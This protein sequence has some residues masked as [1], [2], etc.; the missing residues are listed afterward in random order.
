MG[1][2]SGLAV[3]LA[4]S[5]AVVSGWT[6]GLASSDDSPGPVGSPASTSTAGPDAAWG[7]PNASSHDVDSSDATTTNPKDEAVRAAPPGVVVGTGGPTQDASASPTK[8]SPPSEV[9]AQPETGADDGSPSTPARSNGRDAV[10]PAR[11][12][13]S[14]TLSAVTGAEQDTTLSIT[15]T[16]EHTTDAIKQLTGVVDPQERTGEAAS[17]RSASAPS[18]AVATPTPPEPSPPQGVGW[19]RGSSTR[20]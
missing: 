16:T 17:L 4:V 7:K 15:A 1:R 14:P 12:R 6:C 11:T 20:S 5:A 2:I 19:C 13:A 3:G 10:K 18:S 9:D 8:S